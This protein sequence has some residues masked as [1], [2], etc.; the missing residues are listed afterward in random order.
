MYHVNRPVD[1]HEKEQ[2]MLTILT[3][4]LV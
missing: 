4:W 1:P 2:G 3:Y